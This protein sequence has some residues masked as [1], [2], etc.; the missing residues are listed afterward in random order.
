MKV[1][2]SRGFCAD[3]TGRFSAYRQMVGFNDA[4]QLPILVAGAWLA[5]EFRR[6]V[7]NGWS[8]VSGQLRAKLVTVTCS[9]QRRPNGPEQL[10]CYH[11]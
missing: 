9:T 4:G 11:V 3:E 10:F 7:G 6:F 8:K 2:E 5:E 1:A